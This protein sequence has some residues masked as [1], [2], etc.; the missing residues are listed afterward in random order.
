VSEPPARSAS[1]QPDVSVIIPVFNEEEGIGTCH[2][3]VSEVLDGAGLSYEL[4]YVDDGS[5]DTSW[6]K[7]EAL[8]STPAPSVLV[9]LRRN[10]GQQKALWVGLHHAWGDVVVTYDSDLQFVP[11][12]I[13]DL[14]HKAR[15]G[16]EIVGG[17]RTTRRDPLFRNR[18]PSW[19]GQFLI[20][21]AL[22]V[23]QKD[24]GGVKAYRHTLVHDLKRLEDAYLILPAAAYKL[25][26]NF[27]EIPVGHQPRMVGTTKW[28]LVR[29]MEFYLHIYTTHAPRPFTWM[30]VG[31]LGLLMVSVLLGIAIVLYRFL[32]GDFRGTIVFFDVFLF[33]TGMQLFCFALIGEF[34]VRTFRGRATTAS[35]ETVV[36]EVQRTELPA[37]EGSEDAAQ[38]E[39]AAAEDESG[40]G[41]GDEDG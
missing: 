38:P 33:V 12:C 41:D 23:V 15:E 36:E 39:E 1:A 32:V 2:T 10:E 5:T 7:M 13:P 27:V 9:K 35:W 11:E 4:I 34:V 28:S 19:A 17:I 22:G 6:T 16:F 37:S 18:I 25:T 21:R 24:F 8:L 31:G 14:V 29:R 30:L 3:R 20:N 40:D 26:K